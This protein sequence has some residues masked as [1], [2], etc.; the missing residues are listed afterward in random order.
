MKKVSRCEN[1][2][3]ELYTNEY[4]FCK[5]CWQEVGTDFLNKLDAEQQEL[6]K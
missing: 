5:R 3:R 4:N 6:D 2:E 1:C